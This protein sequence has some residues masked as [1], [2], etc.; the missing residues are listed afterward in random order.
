MNRLISRSLLTLVGTAILSTNVMA[1]EPAVCKN[2]RLG[3]VNWT[4]VMATSAMTQVLLDGLGYKTKQTSASQQIIFAGIRDQ[5]LDMF[6]GYWNPIMTQTI[7]PSSTPG[8]SRSLN[9]PA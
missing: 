5:R 2:V 4:D 9:N 7:T 6:L 1:A 8:R 3:V